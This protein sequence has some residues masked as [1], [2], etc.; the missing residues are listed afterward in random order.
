VKGGVFMKKD[1]NHYPK[2]CHIIDSVICS[3]KVQ[4]IAESRTGF[5]VGFSGSTDVNI[6]VTVHED[7]IDQ[8]IVVIKDKIVNI[9]VV[10]VT[11]IVRPT[12]G[13]G[14]IILEDI[15]R[16][17]EET[18]CPGVCPEDTVTETPLQVEAVI[19]QAIQT[20]SFN[21]GTPAFAI[22]VKVILRTRITAT[23]QV[24]KSKDGCLIDVNENR[25]EAPIPSIIQP[26]TLL[27]GQTAFPRVLS[28]DNAMLLTE[29]ETLN[30]SISQ[31]NETE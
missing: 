26:P 3:K 28:T 4:K 6:D 9:G 24:V 13:P 10:P 22:V 25:C 17:Q 15:L 18:E 20:G 11:I 19:A 2:D 30:S 23:R 8:N 31:R 14:S 12:S 5:T 7:R 29:N 16:F 27:R 1:Q 21:G